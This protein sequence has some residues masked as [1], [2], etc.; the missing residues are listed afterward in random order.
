VHEQVGPLSLRPCSVEH[1]L[2]PIHTPRA[3]APAVLSLINRVHIDKQSGRRFLG[4]LDEARLVAIGFPKHRGKGLAIVM[5]ADH[6]P[7]RES[8][9]ERAGFEDALELTVALLTPVM[10]Q[11]AG[12]HHPVGI[13]IMR[14]DM[15]EAF[16]EIRN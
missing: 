12:D 4:P 10:G 8:A 16:L 7:R 13:M 9:F 6:Q 14:L 5:I 3:I 15:G 2:Q 1:R 11:V